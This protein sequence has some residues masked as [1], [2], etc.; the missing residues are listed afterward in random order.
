MV[1]KIIE[2]SSEQMLVSVLNGKIPQS[3][4]KI[5]IPSGGG[6]YNIKFVRTICRDI[7]RE[8]FSSSSGGIRTS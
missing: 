6:L 7:A 3:V 2:C 1:F 5:E 8:K 4:R